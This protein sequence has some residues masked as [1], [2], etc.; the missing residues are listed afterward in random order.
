MK[1]LYFCKLKQM[2][3]DV[4]MYDSQKL[5]ERIKSV[6]KEKGVRVK[7]VLSACDLNP[8]TLNQISDKK[9]LSSFS[10]AKIADY[11]E[12][13][14]DYLLG[15]TNSP[16]GCFDDFVSRNINNIS[17]SH[18]GAVGN[19]LTGTI[20]IGSGDTIP[21]NEQKNMPTLESDERAIEI[22]RILDK[23]PLKERSKLMTMIYNFEEK[24]D[25]KKNSK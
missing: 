22:L 10:L 9:G 18:V 6:A 7:N 2:K 1:F 21:N 16:N 17:N 12:C 14:V 5:I 19:T 15:R 13:S 20:N 23:L 11:L 4:F 24:Y 8:N 25:V 3:G